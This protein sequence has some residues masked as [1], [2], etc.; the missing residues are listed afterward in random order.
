MSNKPIKRGDYFLLPYA[1]S[2]RDNL[3]RVIRPW[4]KGSRY[5]VLCIT[6]GAESFAA[7][8]GTAAKRVPPSVA[9]RILGET[10]FNKLEKRKKP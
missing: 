8:D 4:P 10:T 1:G 9:K 2:R 5:D 3:I 7:L 6:L